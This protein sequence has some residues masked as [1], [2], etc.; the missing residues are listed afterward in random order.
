MRRRARSILLPALL[1]LGGGCNAQVVDA[2]RDPP[3]VEKPPDA[4]APEPP[5]PLET[6]LIHRYGFDGSG[7]QA[8][9]SKGAAHGQVVGTKLDG[10]GSL[11][12]AGERSGQYVNLPNGMVS[13]LRNATF[14]AWLTWQGGGAWQRIFDFGNSSQG[15]DMPALGV[16][17]FFLTT[18]SSIDAG[19]GSPGTLRTA[20]SLNGVADEDICQ[21][22]EPFPTGVATHVAV[23]VDAARGR[24]ALY[25]N[26]ALLDECPL[27]RPLSAIDDENDWLG[28]SNFAADVDLQGSFDE[29]RV[30]AAALTPEQLADS[31]AQGPDAGR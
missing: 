12:L 2:V 17:Y 27:T 23:V 3:P 26:G 30:Y 16:R 4:P 15:E 31:F 8:L 6:S 24:F 22:R 14:E 7:A 1:A 5:S 9:D 11:P 18:A 25:Q 19:R 20:Y 28:H 21:G 13:G 10:S 29:F